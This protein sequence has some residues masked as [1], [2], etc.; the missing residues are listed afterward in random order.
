EAIGRARARGPRAHLRHVALTGRGPAGRGRRLE[1]VDARVARPAAVVGRVVVA[2]AALGRA[3]AA[4]RGRGEAVRR[5]RA[6]G[7]RAHLR[8]V[9]LTGR[10]PA[11]RGRRLEDV[12][13]RV[14]RPAAVIGRVVVA[15]AALGRARAAR[16]GRVDACSRARARGPRAHLRHVA[17]TGRGPAGGG[18][19]LEDVDARVARPPAVLGSVVVAR[20]ALGRA[21]AARRGRGEAIGRARARG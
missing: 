4:R 5:A 10:G 1:D 11:G 21:R 13:A 3:R 2:R 20:A 7:P 8:Y 18:P 9:A 15:R 19:R 17:L 16:R 6:R 12:D 14:A